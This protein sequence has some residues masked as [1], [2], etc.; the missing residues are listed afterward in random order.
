[1][2][3]QSTEFMHGGVF[4]LSSVVP[5]STTVILCLSTPAFSPRSGCDEMSEAIIL[6]QL[7]EK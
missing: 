5:H 3:G 1:M 4:F 7:I 6:K 2:R